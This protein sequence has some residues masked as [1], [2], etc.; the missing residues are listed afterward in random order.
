[1]GA[2]PGIDVA[3]PVI[4]STGANTG[5][6]RITALHLADL[7]ACMVLAGRDPA[8][9]AP[10]VQ[11]IIQRTGRADAARYLPLDLGDLHAVRQ[12]AEQFL[13][14]GMPLHALINNAG[15]AGAKGQ[16]RQGFELAFGTN[17]LGHFHLTQ[18][19]LPALLQTPM[20]RVVTVASRAHLAAL[21]GIEWDRLTQPT[22]TRF[23]ITEYAVSKLANILFA[24]ELA[25]LHGDQGLLS[26]SLHPGVI[27][28]EVWRHA[29][30]WAQPLFALRRMKT[31]QEGA[32]TSLH[33]VL[34]A[35]ADQNGLYFS[36]AQ[37]RTPGDHARNP[38]LARQ[39]WARSLAWTQDF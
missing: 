23:G 36:S 12:A 25:R 3:H 8:R 37:P 32:Q 13:S 16:T 34:K 15:V 35:T 19:L 2:L 18:L 10:V 7:G 1:M 11:D 30:W 38:L 5:I 9:T 26:Y 28:T 20:S 27:K 17:H 21:N 29:P 4:L 31:P 6:G 24:S 14:W 33:C 39:L 22:R